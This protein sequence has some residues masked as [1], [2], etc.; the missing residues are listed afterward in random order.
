MSL[1][2]LTGVWCRLQG[3]LPPESPRPRP[4]PSTLSPCHGSFC[5]PWGPLVCGNEAAIGQTFIPTQPLLVVQLGQ[6]SPPQRQAYPGVFPLVEPAPAGTRAARPSGQLAPL[7]PVQSIQRMPSK[8]RRSSTRGRPPREQ[9]VGSGRCT[10]SASHCCL[11]NARHAMCWPPVLLGNAR[12]YHP[13][14]VRF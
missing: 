11:V 1:Q 9:T 3:L 10:R 6:E 13:P 8:Q 7:A 14:T 5:R 4:K 2:P 12:R